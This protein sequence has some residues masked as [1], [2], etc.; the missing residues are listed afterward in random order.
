M[1]ENRK[2]IYSPITYVP[3]K[4]FLI[5]L[6][7]F[8]ITIF[9]VF[10][11][12][13]WD[14]LSFNA[15]MF[16]YYF[17]KDMRYAIIFY[18]VIIRILMYPFGRIRKNLSQKIEIAEKEL[19]EEVNRE[20][21]PVTKDKAK[22]KWLKKYKKILAF[23]WFS[24]GFYTMNA[25]CVGY[26]F[27]KN[28]T[29]E[30]TASQIWA[31][32]L[33]PQFPLNTTG[34]IP[35]VGIVDLTKVNMKLNLYSAIGA[36]LVGLVEIIMHQKTSRKQLLMYLVMFPLGAFFLTMWVPS[37]FEFGLIIIEILTILIVFVEKMVEFSKKTFTIPE[38]A[39]VKEAE[40]K[41]LPQEK[42]E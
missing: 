11:F 7:L 24:F 39:L 37:G 22:R 19:A 18:A 34:Y 14:N 5:I 4:D 36:G 33:M 42:E 26:I 17:T 15:I 8:S 32:F 9:Y 21:H 20:R 1:S 12:K 38:K 16:G 28:F 13:Y 41:D 6:I 27:L 31:D 29:P 35:L 23:E 40:T 10:A 2:S 25:V 3:Q 30:N